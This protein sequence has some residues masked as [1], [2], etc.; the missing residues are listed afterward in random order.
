[1]KKRFKTGTSDESFKSDIS[2]RFADVVVTFVIIV[3]FKNNSWY[4]RID[5]A[6]AVDE[7]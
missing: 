1:M 3:Y 4:T 5:L 2:F 7:I 6:C